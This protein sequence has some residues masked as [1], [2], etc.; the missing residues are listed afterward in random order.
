[1]PAGINTKSQVED[2]A[3]AERWQIT[4]IMNDTQVSGDQIPANPPA[5]QINADSPCESTSPQSRREIYEK[6]LVM[7][8]TSAPARAAVRYISRRDRLEHPDGWQDSGGR[9]YPN[10]SEGLDTGRY[11]LPSRSYPWSYMHACRT[12]AHCAKLERCTKLLLVRRIA[13]AIDLAPTG[14]TSIAAVRCVINAARRDSNTKKKSRPAPVA[15][16]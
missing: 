10:E 14:D 4:N 3:I 1:M 2:R 6:L 9:W 8:A 5:T 12:I 13:R 11:R 16:E 7:F 15:G